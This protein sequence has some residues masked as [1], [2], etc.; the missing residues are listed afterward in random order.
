MTKKK[1]K[2]TIIIGIVMFYIL[3]SGLMLSICEFYQERQN[4]RTISNLL[5]A[6]YSQSVTVNFEEVETN[7]KE[8]SDASELQ[9]CLLSNSLT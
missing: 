1:M 3:S 8:K 2:K 7:T 4:D 6:D 9:P 5:S